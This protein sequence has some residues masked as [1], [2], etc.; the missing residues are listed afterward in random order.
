M[1]HALAC[2]LC[3][4]PTTCVLSRAEQRVVERAAELGSNSNVPVNLPPPETA[5]YG[6]EELRDV[7]RL[8]ERL[9]VPW[10][11]VAP[12]AREAYERAVAD[13]R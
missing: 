9:D 1:S 13:A 7:Q 5:P 6:A 12:H 4:L 3:G 11:R 2:V 8:A 10:K